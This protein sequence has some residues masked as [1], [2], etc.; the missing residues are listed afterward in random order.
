LRSDTLQGHHRADN[1]SKA[2]RN[3]ERELIDHVGHVEHQFL[4]VH[5]AQAYAQVTIEQPFNYGFESGFIFGRELN[6]AEPDHIVHHAVNISLDHVEKRVNQI[7]WH[8]HIK[9]PDHSEVE[10]CQAAVCHYPKI[11]RVRI[12]M[13]E[14]IFQ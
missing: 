5:I 14:A 10:E 13:K 3:L 1:V 7:S 12:S 4:E 2:R 6:K 8:L 9:W 11:S